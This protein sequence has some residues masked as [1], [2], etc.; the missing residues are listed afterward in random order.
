MN[1]T[2]E[3]PI[4]I[5]PGTW[6]RIDVSTEERTKTTVREVVTRFVG[7]ADE[8]ATIRAELRS[9]LTVIAESARDG[10]AVEFYVAT[11]VAPSVPLTATLSVHA[12]QWDIARLDEL[13]ISG[14]E[15]VLLASAAGMSGER[16]GERTMDAPEIAVVRQRYRREVDRS[17]SGAEPLPLIQVDYWVAAPYPARLALLSFASPMTAFEEELVELFDAVVRTARWP[18]A[19]HSRT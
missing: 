1:P 12:P 11:E 8:A 15:S 10:G 6:G 17:A 9:Q 18:V 2:R 19:A 3:Y 7:R 5:L 14:L 16:V 13:G 4:F